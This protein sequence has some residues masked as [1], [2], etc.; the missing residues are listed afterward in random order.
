LR[1]RKS[2]VKDNNEYGGQYRQAAPGFYHD[3]F[4]PIYAD[5]SKAW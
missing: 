2:S 1:L 3:I 5:H 4:L